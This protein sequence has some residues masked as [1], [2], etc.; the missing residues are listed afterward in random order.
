MEL[1]RDPI[2]ESS[3]PMEVTSGDSTSGASIKAWSS[4]ATDIL[5]RSDLTSEEKAKLQN[6]IAQKDPKLIAAVE[7][8]KDPS[9]LSTNVLKL[10]RMDSSTAMVEEEG[11]AKLDAAWA[12]LS[13]APKKTLQSSLFQIS[14][15]LE[16]LKKKPT[17]RKSRQLRMDN[18]VIKK[19][20][21]AISGGQEFFEAVGFQVVESGGKTY[22]QIEPPI[23]MALLEQAIEMLATKTRDLDDTTKAPTAVRKPCAG[24][25][26]S[27]FGS[28]ATDGMCSI[29]YNKKHGLGAS[30]QPEEKKEA[31]VKCK[32]GCGFYGM[33]KFKGFCSQCYKKDATNRRK[34]L[35]R[36]WRGAFH[37]VRACRRFTMFLKP[38]QKHTNR[39][40]QCNKRIGITGVECRCGYVFC[41]VHRYA[42]QHNCSFDYRK[43]QRKKLEKENFQLQRKKFERI[44][45]DDH[46]D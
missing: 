32:A 27:F 11:Q 43:L 16:K 5:Q 25:G 2:A 38:V 10:V 44:Q 46:N 39:C 40:W 37:T 8:S 4:V 21:T 22:L 19:Y 42:D 26:C 36:K 15:L 35:K 20:V 17:D 12:T 3:G 9:Q 28:D 29:C 1:D 24:L 23:N 31:A 14:K 34:D 45:S 33:S 6:M 7:G 13:K 41:G 30:G 18:I